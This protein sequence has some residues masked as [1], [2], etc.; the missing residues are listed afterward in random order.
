VLG[1]LRVS[2][3]V[4]WLVLG[5]F[6]LLSAAAIWRFFIPGEISGSAPPAMHAAQ[7]ARRLDWQ[8][9]RLVLCYGVFGFGYI[10]PATF[11]PVMARDALQD[12]ALFGWSWP[13]FGVAAA[14]STLAVAVVVPRVGTRRLW[15]ASHFIMALGVALPVLW[16]HVAAIFVAAL[17]VG[18]TFM[19]ITLCAMQEARSVAGSAAAGLI[20]AMT[21]AFAAGQI[22]GPLSVAWLF[23]G[24]S[25]F[26]VAL[27]VAAASLALGALMLVGRPNHRAGVTRN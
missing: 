27:L 14:L 15:I 11:L 25:G 17:L 7:A 21:A 9:L 3:S 1:Y 10:I 4:A 20:A 2:S 26:S 13:V 12:P 6:S 23:S 19:V 16:T 5:A 8:S 24:H 18:G 22:A